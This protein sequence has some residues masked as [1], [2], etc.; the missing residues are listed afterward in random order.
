MIINP[1]YI[2]GKAVFLISAGRDARET[3]QQ[4]R[5]QINM[6]KRSNAAEQMRNMNNEGCVIALLIFDQTNRVHCALHYSFTG[7]IE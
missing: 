4:T 3:Q 6:A 7:D 1:R 5:G 2:S